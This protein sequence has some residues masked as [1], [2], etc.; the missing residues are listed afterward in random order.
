VVAIAPLDFCFRVNSTR[1]TTSSPREHC[2]AYQGIATRTSFVVHTRYGNE[3]ELDHAAGTGP[4]PLIPDEELERRCYV[5]L[6]IHYRASNPVGDVP[7][8][9]S[10]PTRSGGDVGKVRLILAREAG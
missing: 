6:G 10:H 4:N 7:I 2:L 8:V 9:A 5:A 1:F 3:N